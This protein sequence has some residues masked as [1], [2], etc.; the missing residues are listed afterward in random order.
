[1]P[2]TKLPPTAD[3]LLARDMANPIYRFVPRERLVFWSKRCAVL[4]LDEWPLLFELAAVG[5]DHDSI[6]WFGNTRE[7]YVEGLPIL[8]RH[9]SI[10]HLEGT[11][12]NIIRSLTVKEARGLVAKTMVQLLDENL[13]TP[14]SSKYVIHDK[15]LFPEA[16]EQHSIDSYRFI[17]I[18]NLTVTADP[19]VTADIE[20]LLLDERL[21][22]W[23]KLLKRAL[24]KSKKKL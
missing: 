21:H 4:L 10:P 24:S 22:R 5:Y 17:L 19:S 6:G 7:S 2:T 9:L 13:A 3:E 11:R 1:M 12:S 8:L 23:E 14:L 16:L 18:N 15:E 20:R